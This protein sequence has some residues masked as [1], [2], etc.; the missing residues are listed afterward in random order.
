MYCVTEGAIGLRLRSS[1][2]LRVELLLYINEKQKT[3]VIQEALSSARQIKEEGSHFIALK[4]L[5]PY[6]NRDYQVA[7][8]QEIFDI[9]IPDYF[10]S[11][12]IREWRVIKLQVFER[13][14]IQAIQYISQYDRNNAQL[15]TTNQEV[16]KHKNNR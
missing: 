5:V 16:R 9:Q 14:L 1:A 11:E 6:L 3:S 13:Y 2:N 7:V 12:A 4:N 15:Q 10:L 8:L